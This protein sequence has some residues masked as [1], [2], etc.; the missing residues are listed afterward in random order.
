MAEIYGCTTDD[1]FRDLKK[2]E[3]KKNKFSKWNIT[4]YLKIICG[5]WV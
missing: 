3:K 1:I 5:R 4:R 2:S